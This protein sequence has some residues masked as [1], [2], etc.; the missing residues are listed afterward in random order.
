VPNRRSDDANAAL[1]EAREPSWH[2]VDLELAGNDGAVA[3]D[4]AQQRP[5]DLEHGSV[6][7]DR[8]AAAVE[9]AVLDD[10]RVPGDG[11]VRPVPACDP[12]HGDHRRQ[13]KQ[14]RSGSV[15]SGPRREEARA[16]GEREHER[17]Q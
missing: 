4:A 6:E 1:E 17:P 14:H 3:E 15:R 12:D 11:K 10:E 8:R 16:A 9:E 13:C 5:L 7:R 2:A